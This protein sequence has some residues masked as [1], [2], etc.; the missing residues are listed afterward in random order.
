MRY[1]KRQYG[2]ATLEVGVATALP[3]H[4][5]KGI[6]MISK[7]FTDPAC[8]RQGHAQK[9]LTIVAAEADLHRKLLLLKVGDGDADAAT[10]Q[11]LL[12]WYEKNGFAA[13]QAEPLLMVRPHAAMV[14]P[15]PR[16]GDG[17][18]LSPEQPSGMAER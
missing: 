11:N 16:K 9:L 14:T 8:R 2:G 18:R 1:G 7:V 17:N 15:M 6:A 5:R 10:K 4:M 3:L 12:S 13:I